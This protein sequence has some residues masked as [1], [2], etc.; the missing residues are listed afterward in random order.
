MTKKNFSNCES[1]DTQSAGL[2]ELLEVG[3]ERKYKRHIRE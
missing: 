1:E 2:A 3:F